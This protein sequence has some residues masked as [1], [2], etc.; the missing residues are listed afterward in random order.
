MSNQQLLLCI[1]YIFGE[2]RISNAGVYD[3]I[4]VS[5]GVVEYFAGGLQLHVRSLQGGLLGTA[6]ISN[7]VLLVFARWRHRDAERAIC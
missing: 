4:R 7:C 1:L 6:A 3:D 5:T 2:I